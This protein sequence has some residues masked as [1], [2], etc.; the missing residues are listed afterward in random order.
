MEAH[1]FAFAL[2]SL[3]GE[4]GEPLAESTIRRATRE[5]RNQVYTDTLAHGGRIEDPFFNFVVVNKTAVFTFFESDFRVFV[6]RCDE[7]ELISQMNSFAMV[8]TEECKSYLAKVY[9]KLQPDLVVSRAV[10]EHWLDFA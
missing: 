5:C 8:E 1:E 10:S 7:A 4:H 6:L 3:L 2:G 9:R